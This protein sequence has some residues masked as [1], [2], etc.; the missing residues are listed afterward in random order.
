VLVIDLDPQA[1]ASICLAGDSLL[2]TLIARKATIE[3]FLESNLLGNKKRVFR[4]SSG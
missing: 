4:E 1:N 3:A 2:A